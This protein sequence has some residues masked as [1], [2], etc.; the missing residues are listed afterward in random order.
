MTDALQ[1]AEGER[2]VVRVFSLTIEAGTI[3]ALRAPGALASALGVPDIDANAV[4]LFPIE[5][6][7][8]VGLSSYLEDGCG[9]PGAVIAAD[10]DRLDAVEGVV[11]VVLSAAFQGRAARLDPAAQ[12]QLLGVYSE[13]P[14]DW[15]EGAPIETASALPRSTT[16]PPPRQARAQARV[17]GMVVFAVFVVILLLLLVV[18]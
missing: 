12:L 9:V 2:G 5:D 17:A 13:T 3:Q 16:G 7:A 14:T 8:G 18:L 4:E 11:L 10:R 1:V 6:L 15:S